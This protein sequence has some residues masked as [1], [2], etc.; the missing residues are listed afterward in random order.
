MIDLHT[1]SSASDGS[2]SP[3]EILALA[4]KTGLTALAITDHDTVSGL[5]EFEQ[6]ST[7]LQYENAV[8]GVEMSVKI[9]NASLHICGLFIDRKNAEL[10]ALLK[11]IRG[12]RDERNLAIA[13]KLLALGYKISVDDVLKIAKGES[14]GRPH[15]AKVLVA[16]GYFKNTQE[17]FD[18]ALKR[19]TCAYVDRMLPA[20]EEAISAI[21]GAGGLVFW[22]H[23]FGRKNFTK[24]RFISLLHELTQIGLDGIEAYYSTYDKET[25]KYLLS[26]SEKEGIL[27][28]GGS[29][30]HGTNM[31]GIQIG[32]GDG[33]MAIPDRIFQEL[34]D[35]WLGKR[36]WTAAEPVV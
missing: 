29:D 5:E 9:P 34:R 33:N 7:K 11:K 19:G 22:A 15:F 16:K 4:K 23:P 18:R 10:L 26:V 36:H 14:V 35:S 25:E 8:Q 2:Y 13:E 30:F 24:P 6:A 3:S 31:D 32:T 20:P 27:V 12:K 28:S 17:A 1:H 21:H